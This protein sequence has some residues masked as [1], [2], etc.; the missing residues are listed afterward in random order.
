M[1]I[2]ENPKREMWSSV[3]Q[4]PTQT[5]EDIEATVTEIFQD[6]QIHCDFA[7]SKYTSIFDDV[8]LNNIVV[9]KDEITQASSLISESLK[10][11]I[12]TAKPL[13]VLANTMM[14]ANIPLPFSL[15]Q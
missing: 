12:Q 9:S 3:L 5:V 14:S 10:T 13:F 8:E 6:V 4:R 7:I 1:K 11:A 2:I 15:L